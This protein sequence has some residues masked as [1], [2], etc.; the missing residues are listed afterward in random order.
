MLERWRT[1][2]PDEKL[3]RMFG[4]AALVNELARSD[5]REL[6]LEKLIWFREAGESERQWQD[7]AGVVAVRR[8]QLD[9]D[10]LLR[11]AAL[12][13]LTASLERLLDAG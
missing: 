3:D 8:D 9:R 10:Y 7:A 11:H 12:L 4:M 13:D 1:A 2:T 5:L 6:I